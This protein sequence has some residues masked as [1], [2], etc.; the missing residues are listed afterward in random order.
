[1]KM[2]SAG[3][4]IKAQRT[5]RIGLRM[6]VII[7]FIVSPFQ[8]WQ[9]FALVKRAALRRSA[10]IPSRRV[11]LLRNRHGSPCLFIILISRD[12]PL[13]G[14][15]RNAI[16]LHNEIAKLPSKGLKF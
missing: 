16:S 7:E 8:T 11:F 3:S 13:T 12:S 14:A 1:M 15:A 10:G 5:A 2:A 6:R 4:N 9:P